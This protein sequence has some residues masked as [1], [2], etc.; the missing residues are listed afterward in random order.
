MPVKPSLESDSPDTRTRRAWIRDIVAVG[1][2]VA[3]LAM[4]RQAIAQ[5]TFDLIVAAQKKLEVEDREL[6]RVYQQ[7]LAE[8]ADSPD[9]CK[10]LRETQRAWLKFM[11][12]HIETKYFVPEG[13]VAQSIYGTL[14]PLDLIDERRKMIKAR[15]A[16]LQEG[17]Q[18]SPP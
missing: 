8:R 5:S 17:L 2:F 7:I 15:T 4:P 12:L 13:E 3:G 9:F 6:N 10:R 18:I 16:Q 1:S 11:E 14:H